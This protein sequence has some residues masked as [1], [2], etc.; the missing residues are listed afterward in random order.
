MGKPGGVAHSVGTLVGGTAFA[1]IITILALPLLTRLYGPEEFSLLAVYVSLTGIL[2]TV[3]CLRF[4]IA[5][6]LPESDEEASSLL[7]LALACGLIVSILTGVTFLALHEQIILLLR[8]PMFDSYLRLVPIGVFVAS[9]YVAFQYWS[10]RR[11]KFKRIAKTRVAQALGGVGLQFSV[12]VL[13]GGAI[14]LIL[15]QMF[16]GGAGFIG[17]ARDAWQN[18]RGPLSRVTAK[19]MWQALTRYSRFPKFSAP[20]ALA[21]TAAFQLPVLIVAALVI[22]PE[23]GYLMLASRLMTA[24]M[25]LLGGS[26]AQ[27]YVA[28]ASEERRDGRLGEFS[29][30][31]LSGLLKTGVGPLLFAGIVAN[32]LIGVIFGEKWGRTGVLIAWMAPWFV[33]QFLSSPVS[34]VMHVTGRQKEMLLL[35]TLGLIGRLGVIWAAHQ[36]LGGFLSEAFA[37]SGAVFYAVCCFVFFRSAGVRMFQVVAALREASRVLVAWIA[38]GVV[39]SFCVRGFL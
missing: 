34:M 11:K 7:A 37:V 23:A 17:L 39:V 8:M 21:N 25:A 18:D 14:G 31:M 5:I 26:I 22:G 16:S 28:H 33:L 27:V 3:A 12:G 4:E 38:G 2:T 24:P 15:G 10:T 20:E 36:L 1:Q 32:P 29:V 19:S 35:T 13:G 9:A 30:R 6:P